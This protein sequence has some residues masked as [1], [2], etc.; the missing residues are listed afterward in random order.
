MDTN[1]YKKYLSA[2]TMMGP[3]SVRILEELF[4]KYPLQF[5]SDDL[6]LDLGCGKGLTSL[7]IAKETGAKER[8]WRVGDKMYYKKGVTD[9][10]YCVLRFTA[11]KGR[12]YNNFKSVDFDIE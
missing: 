5:T 6:I 4:D 11:A 1:N 10:D 3:N 2:E 7:V 9:P 8:I 12:Y